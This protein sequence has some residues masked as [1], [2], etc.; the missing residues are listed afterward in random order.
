MM[1]TSCI[2][3]VVDGI[4]LFFFIVCM[5]H[6]FLIHSSVNGHLGYLHVVSWAN[7]RDGRSLEKEAVDPYMQRWEQKEH[8]DGYIVEFRLAP[9]G[10]WTGSG[11]GCMPP[12]MWAFENQ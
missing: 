10:Q 3:V 2:H 5:Y 6:I 12:T 9:S 8:Q 7:I 11:Q 4:I 1:I